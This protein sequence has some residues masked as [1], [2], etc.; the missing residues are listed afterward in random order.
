MEG[1][2]GRD[3]VDPWAAR[4]DYGTVLAASGTP[5]SGQ[6]RA[7]FLASHAASGTDPQRVWAWMEAERLRLEAWSSCAWFFDTADRIETRQTVH[8][9]TEAVRRP[10]ALGGVDLRE[11]LDAQWRDHGLGDEEVSRPSE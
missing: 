6:V 8:Q 3:L 5:S 2:A 4:D 11:W 1:E 10:S 7:S 9:A